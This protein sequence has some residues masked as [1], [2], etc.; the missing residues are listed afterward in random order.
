MKS[1]ININI[2]V[3]IIII[4]DTPI[5]SENLGYKSLTWEN[6]LI[7]YLLRLEKKYIIIVIEASYIIDL[8]GFIEA[9][10]IFIRNSRA[11]LKKKQIL[12][13]I[14]NIYKPDSN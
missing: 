4:I 5:S 13:N 2:K 14:Y 6:I 7:F 3:Y 12:D 11:N 10:A 1:N 9:L 8:K